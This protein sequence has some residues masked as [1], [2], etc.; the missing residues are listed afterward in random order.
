MRG[1]LRSLSMSGC[2]PQQATES[3]WLFTG[4]R[5]LLADAT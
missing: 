2:A 1:V 4:F 3:S 5:V